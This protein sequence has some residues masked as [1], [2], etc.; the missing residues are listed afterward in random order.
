MDEIYLGIYSTLNR[1]NSV[2]RT[3]SLINVTLLPRAPYESGLV[4][5]TETKKEESPKEEDSLLGRF[6]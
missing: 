1:F 5:S 4:P 3:P 2:G 6:M